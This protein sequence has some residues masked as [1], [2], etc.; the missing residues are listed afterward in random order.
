MKQHIIEFGRQGKKRCQSILRA[1]ETNQIVAVSKEPDGKFLV[2]EKCDDYF[3]C[4]LTAEQLRALG[5][6]LI[7]LADENEHAGTGV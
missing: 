3:S 4:R 6:E 5:H 1:L 7:A 2:S